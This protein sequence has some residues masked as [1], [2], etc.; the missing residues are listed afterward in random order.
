MISRRR[1]RTIKHT[2]ISIIL[3][4]TFNLNRSDRRHYDISIT[5]YVS[6]FYGPIHQFELR[7]SSRR[8]G[9]IQLFIVFTRQ[10]SDYNNIVEDNVRNYDYPPKNFVNTNQNYDNPPNNVVN[11]NRRLYSTYH[12]KRAFRTNVDVCIHQETL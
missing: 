6:R 4:R 5:S 12:K 1:R 2:A 9:P 7:H 11:T 8:P 3:H 10:G